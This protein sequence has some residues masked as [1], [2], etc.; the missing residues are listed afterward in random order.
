MKTAKD[1]LITIGIAIVM[2]AMGFFFGKAFSEVNQSVVLPSLE[3]IQ[4]RIGAT[5]DGIYGKDTRD[6]WD[7]ALCDQYASEHDYMYGEQK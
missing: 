3:E 6:K 2:L 7:R 4:Q 5:P 1:I